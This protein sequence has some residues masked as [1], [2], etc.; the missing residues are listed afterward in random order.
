MVLR[1]EAVDS[2][3]NHFHAMV[4]SDLDGTLLRR[5]HTVSPT[6]LQTL[7]ALGN[8]QV[9]R[10]IATGRSLYSA[11][12]VLPD[13]FPIEYLIFSSGAGVL[14]WRAKTLVQKHTLSANE[15]ERA[16][17][18]LKALSAD[19]MIHRPVPDNH[20]FVYYHSGR[21]NPDFAK[22]CEIYRDFAV[23]ADY[24]DPF[25]GE[26][27]EVLAVEPPDANADG[28][29]TESPAQSPGMPADGSPPG[30]LRD[31]RLHTRLAGAFATTYRDGAQSRRSRS[32]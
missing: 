31:P 29:S 18:A 20:Y 17:S 4:V 3:R 14:D 27:C 26:A 10:V 2:P 21:E 25:F 19:F 23:P 12:Q 5:D 30:G 11:R 7:V 32:L 9:L 15:V 24:S 28:G 1:I 22:R 13:A 6:D 8:E 16:V